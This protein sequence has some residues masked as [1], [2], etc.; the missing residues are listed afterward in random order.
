[1]EEI[2][3]SIRRIIADDQSLPGNRREREERRR[4]DP[5]DSPSVSAAAHEYAEPVLEAAPHVEEEK[6]SSVTDDDEDEAPQKSS[7]AEIR[8]LRLNRA[9]VEQAVSGEEAD[10]SDEEEDRGFF[11]AHVA[12]VAVEEEVDAVDEPLVSATTASSVAS[13]FEA[14]ATSMFLKDQNLLQQYAQEMMRPMLKQWLDDN[15]P[16]IVERLVRAEIERVARGGR[17]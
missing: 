5:E 17:R 9:A 11:P 7:V 2:L 10:D 4:R 12:E 14:L 1:M 13:H 3:A 15:L 6:A 8:H 16:T